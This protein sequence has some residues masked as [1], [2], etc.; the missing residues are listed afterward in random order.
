[1]AGGESGV[2][3]YT[4]H[5]RKHDVNPI[6]ECD[7]AVLILLLI[8]ICLPPLRQRVVEIG[9]IKKQRGKTTVIVEPSADMVEKTYS[10]K[11]YEA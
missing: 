5:F 4:P 6:N 9:S 7:P 10:T 8:I 1:M 3:R 2:D 11:S